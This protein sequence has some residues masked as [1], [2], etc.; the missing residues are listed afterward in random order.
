MQYPTNYKLVMPTEHVKQIGGDLDSG[1]NTCD[2][3]HSIDLTLVH[4]TN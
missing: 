2:I 1:T 3:H 4:L